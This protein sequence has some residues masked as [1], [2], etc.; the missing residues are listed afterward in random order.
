MKAGMK[1]C[2]TRLLNSVISVYSY[3]S[4]VHSLYELLFSMIGGGYFYS[5]SPSKVRETMIA[6]LGKGI[7]CISWVIDSIVRV[8]QA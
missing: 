4:S 3:I 2:A 1:K 6:H 8:S 5:G 7:P